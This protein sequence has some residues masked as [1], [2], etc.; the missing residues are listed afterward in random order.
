M[1]GQLP[2]APLAS[3]GG[4]ERANCFLGIA[5]VVKRS[6]LLVF[7]CV[8]LPFLAHVRVECSPCGGLVRKHQRPARLAFFERAGVKNP[9]RKGLRAGRSQRVSRVDLS[10][11]PWT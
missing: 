5:G 10:A 1:P 4:A 11:F 3:G 7:G 6:A 9:Y 2:C 8:A